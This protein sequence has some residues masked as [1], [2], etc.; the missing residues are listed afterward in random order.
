M[1]VMQDKSTSD[2]GAVKCDRD[3]CDAEGELDDSWMTIEHFD[4]QTGDLR[5]R[6]DLCADCFQGFLAF[7]EGGDV[8]S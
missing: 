4:K 6:L 8:S 1:S 3:G 2:V 5:N 7:C